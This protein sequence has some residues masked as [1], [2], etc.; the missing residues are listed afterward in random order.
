MQRKVIGALMIIGGLVAIA[1]ALLMVLPV[2]VN[3]PA[4]WFGIVLMVLFAVVGAW[5]VYKGG[6]W[7]I[8]PKS[9]GPNS[10]SSR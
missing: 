10:G 3:L 2:G 9:T 7:L 5:L 6:S 8:Y 4:S 1:L